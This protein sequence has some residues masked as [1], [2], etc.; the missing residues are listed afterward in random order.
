MRKTLL[1]LS[2]IGLLM[3][4]YSQDYIEIPDTAFER[5]LVDSGHDDIIDGYILKDNALSINSIDML[6][7]TDFEDSN[8]RP[9]NLSCLSEFK[10]LESLKVFT[11]SLVEISLPKESIKL[12]WLFGNSSTS[13]IKLPSL[14]FIDGADSLKELNLYSQNLQDSDTNLYLNAERIIINGVTNLKSL[15]INAKRFPSSTFFTI[16]NISIEANESLKTVSFFNMGRGLLNT[17]WIQGNA[18]LEHININNGSQNTVQG[19]NIANNERLQ[20]IILDNIIHANPNISENTNLENITIIDSVY[21][22]TIQNNELD[23]LVLQGLNTLNFNAT[24]IESQLKAIYIDG[25]KDVN[26]N[27][28]GNIS[29]NNA[30]VSNAE[31]ISGLDLSENEFLTCL[32]IEGC[33]NMSNINLDNCYSLSCVQVESNYIPIFPNKISSQ[34]S[35]GS[36]AVTDEC[37]DCDFT[38]P[39]YIDEDTTIVGRL[40]YKK[41]LFIYPNPADDLIILQMES[42]DYS[43]LVVRN[44]TGQIVMQEQINN[45]QMQLDV[46]AL[47]SGLYFIELQGKGK[48]ITEKIIIR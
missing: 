44:I 33:T 37:S 3:T 10:N 45:T 28:S 40:E 9:K 18:N 12:I 1:F 14:E 46:S 19:M 7:N 24:V 41:E 36:Y 13:D 11:H 42:N 30:V 38:I 39:E 26:L 17:F 34:E 31:S 15:I 5:Y 4:T 25:F 2:V 20:S 22:L 32:N 43:S 27:L 29:L 16:S 48:S 47:Q 23:T 6:W 8:F 21:G 35:V